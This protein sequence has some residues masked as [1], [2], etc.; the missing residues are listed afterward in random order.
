MIQHILQDLWCLHERRFV[1]CDIKEENIL[2]S[3]ELNRF[4]VMDFGS[5]TEE[6]KKVLSGT[7]GCIV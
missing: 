7:P 2:F 3:F 5:T 6:G 4:V 1:H